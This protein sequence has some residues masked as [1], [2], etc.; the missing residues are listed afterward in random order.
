MNNFEKKLHNLKNSP[1]LRL[2]SDRSSLIRSNLEKIISIEE[3]LSRPSGF[4]WRRILVPVSSGVV[5]VV[6]GVVTL[7]AEASVPGD[8]LYAIKTK[9]NEPIMGAIARGQEGEIAYRAKMVSRRA[10]ENEIIAVRYEKDKEKKEVAIK[11]L[12]KSLENFEEHARLAAESQKQSVAASYAAQV[13][14]VMES[15]QNIM[16]TVSPKDSQKAR[17]KSVVRKE[18]DF[19]EASSGEFGLMSAAPVGSAPAQDI[20]A[21]EVNDVSAQEEEDLSETEIVLLKIKNQRAEWETNISSDNTPSVEEGAKR[22]VEYLRKKINKSS[23]WEADFLKRSKESLDLALD[24]YSTGSY[25]EAFNL[26]NNAI[27]DIEF[28]ERNE[29]SGRSLK[30]EIGDKEGE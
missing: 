19:S 30:V 5:A 28:L 22:R 6:L 23:G 24:L 11:M 1:H 25:G 21:I 20:S 18:E 12:N 27:K 29:R 26:A 17:A 9:V 4:S 2:S 16:A 10:A 3:S 15:H 14:A 8:V 7:G 13:E